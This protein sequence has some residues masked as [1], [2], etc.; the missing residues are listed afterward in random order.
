[1]AHVSFNARMA[2]RVWKGQKT[3]TRRP[4]PSQPSAVYLHPKKVQGGWQFFE[5]ARGGTGY[6]GAPMKSRYGHVGSLLWVKE[7]YYVGPGP[8]N[9]SDLSRRLTGYQGDLKDLP[10]Q[11]HDRRTAY[12]MPRVWARLMVGVREVAVERLQQIGEVS[13]KA[14]GFCDADDMKAFWNEIYGGTES[15]GSN[16]WVW[17][18]KFRLTVRLK[19]LTLGPSGP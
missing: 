17:V 4:T 19:P 12:Q 7:P 6:P 10:G 14:E 11:G 18:V 3:E 1:M 2:S 5:K 16:P 9:A 8:P 15:W 13:L